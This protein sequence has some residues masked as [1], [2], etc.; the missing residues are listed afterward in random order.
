MATEHCICSPTV[1][2]VHTFCLLA[3]WR[4]CQWGVSYYRCRARGRKVSEPICRNSPTEAVGHPGW[5]TG[6]H[7]STVMRPPDPPSTDLTMHVG[8]LH[9]ERGAWGQWPVNGE[10]VATSTRAPPILPHLIGQMCVSR[11]SCAKT[12][13]QPPYSRRPGHPYTLYQVTTS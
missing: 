8:S 4:S 10:T 7:G 2:K 6:V 11:R 1:N 12:C 5:D 9:G 13:C 3:S